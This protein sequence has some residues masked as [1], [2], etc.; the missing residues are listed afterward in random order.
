MLNSL[1]T[2][3][4]GPLTSWIMKTGGFEMKKLNDLQRT[5]TTKY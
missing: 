4:H 3:E 2:R 1:I 5:R